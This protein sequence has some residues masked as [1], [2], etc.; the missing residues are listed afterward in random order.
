MAYVPSSYN[1]YHHQKKLFRWAII[2]DCL[3]II[4]LI[5]NYFRL[6]WFGIVPG[7]APHNF[8]F[9][10]VFFIPM[11]LTSALI[12]YFVAGQTLLN[13]KRLPD[14]RVKLLIVL[15]TLPIPILL[16]IQIINILKIE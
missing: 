8:S 1:P 9:N 4:A 6:E 2:A 7:Y 11:V 14:I 5:I 16:I 12:A 15:M 13:W 10:F 3:L